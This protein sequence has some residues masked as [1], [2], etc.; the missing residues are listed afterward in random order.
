MFAC[1]RLSY[2]FVTLLGIDQLYGALVKLQI[3]AKTERSEHSRRHTAVAYSRSKHRL[4]ILEVNRIQSKLRLFLNWNKTKM[5]LIKSSCCLVLLW[6]TLHL[7][8]RRK[9][10]LLRFL[11]KLVSGFEGN[12]L[13]S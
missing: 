8:M 4:Y 6:N 3:F 7:E 11:Q 12:K 2:F 10:C 1:L 13:G 5:A 9:L